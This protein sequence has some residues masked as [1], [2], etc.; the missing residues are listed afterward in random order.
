MATCSEEKVVSRNLAAANRPTSE[1]RVVW[2]LELTTDTGS[3]VS[4]DES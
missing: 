4:T 3:V 2:G 1:R